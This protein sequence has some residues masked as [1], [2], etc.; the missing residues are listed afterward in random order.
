[1]RRFLTLALAF[2]VSGASPYQDKLWHLRNLGKAF[3][4]NPT[5]QREA[6]E[7]FKQALALAPNS[8]RERVNY[9]LALLRAG[10]TERGVNE[11]RQAQKQD[12]A[13]PH[14]W[15]NLGIVAKRNGDY[16]TGIEQM[17]RMVQL[18]PG[19]AK[20][21]YNLATLLK[22]QGKLPEAL[23]EFEQAEK[24]DPNLAGPHF[25]LYTAYR[26]AHRQEDANR[27]LATFQEIKKRQAGAPIPEDM[28]ANN[29]TEI[30][31]TLDPTP[32][33][34]PTPEVQF[35]D[36]VLGSGFL[37]MANLNNDLVAWTQTGVEVFG[38]NGSTRPGLG[39]EKVGA[40]V[41]MEPGD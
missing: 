18:V 31:D 4:E 39:L 10:E 33:A 16:A 27:E 38:A 35:R 19:D 34:E 30:L 17:R 36:K 12:P 37:G 7:Q 2:L 32:A 40:V 28:E 23:S 13:I 9:G 11:L 20:A 25:Q 22:L 5:T 29:Y 6:V 1:M 8:A 26:Q 14:T 41:S 15:F 3:Y 24:L 21:H